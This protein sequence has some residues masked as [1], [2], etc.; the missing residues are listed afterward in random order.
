MKKFFILLIALSYLV[1]CNASHI[2]EISNFEYSHK[3]M[4]HDMYLG[5]V[6]KYENRLFINNQYKI[7]ELQILEDGAVEPILMYETKLNNSKSDF[8]DENRYYS[9]RRNELGSHRLLIFD[10]SS[11]PMNL[12]SEIGLPYN[13]PYSVSHIITDNYIYFTDYQ[14]EGSH[15]FNKETMEIDGFLTGLYGGST[16]FQGM[17]IILFHHYQDGNFINVSFRFYNELQ[18]DIELFDFEDFN[19][20]IF[21]GAPNQILSMIIK[22]NKLFLL[23]RMVLYV[24]DLSDIENIE[25]IAFIDERETIIDN[26][27]TGV[28][29]YENIIYTSTA[30]G[31]IMIYELTE[32][33]V[34]NILNYFNELAFGSYENNLVFSS[35][36]LYYTIG[37]M[38]EIFNVSDIDHPIQYYGRNNLTSVYYITEEDFYMASYNLQSGTVDFF[39][40]FNEESYMFSIEKEL[41]NN[42]TS[43]ICNFCINEDLLCFYHRPPENEFY[44]IDVYQITDNNLN[45]LYQISTNYIVPSSVYTKDNLLFIQNDINEIK[46]Y[47]IDDDPEYITSFFGKIL[48]SSGIESD[49]LIYKDN[50][51]LC[52]R[53]LDNIEEI[54]YSI[55]ILASEQGYS[56]I[57]NDEFVSFLNSGT[58]QDRFSVYNYDLFNELMSL[59]DTYYGKGLN[60]FKGFLTDNCQNQDYSIYYNIHNG[61]INEI[62]Q[63]YEQK[64]VGRAFI[65]PELHKM[66]Q[67]AYSGIHVY[68]IEYT[69]SSSDQV[70]EYERDTY[71]YPNPVNGG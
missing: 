51:H 19:D 9:I 35:P 29:I 24:Y 28:D 38:L 21:L 47:N 34:I 69:V 56:N 42:P 14:I 15:R 40:A 6:L 54:A 37:T 30:T 8:I 43:F 4:D 22:N 46:V 53:E 32:D 18:D 7:E 23:G 45:Y 48:D 67:Y 27:F 17:P 59:T 41:L 11:S 5:S 36:Y 55:Q 49:Y 39:S 10:I 52:F 31:I 63:Q 50:N 65:Y 61:E 33:E 58:M 20:E 13:G 1:I 62:G 57:I 3:V 26:Y 60:T 68:D 44:V 25:L 12:L 16:S 71:V 66:V 70:V 64:Y 2:N